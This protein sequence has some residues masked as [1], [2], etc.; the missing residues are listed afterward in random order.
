MKADASAQA[1]QGEGLPRC[2][3]CGTPYPRGDD[4]LGCPVCRLRVALQP[5]AA[6]TGEEIPSS[7][8]L[9]FDH[10][11]VVQRDDGAFEELG[12]GAMGV[13]YKALDTVLGRAVALKVI[14][15]QVAAR[16]E[17]RHTDQV[18]DASRKRLLGEAQLARF[19]LIRGFLGNLLSMV[20]HV[21][22]LSQRLARDPD[23]AIERPA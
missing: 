21:E 5:E 3:A 19:D 1:V 6:A 12:R 15:A 8:E 20:D 9:R 10:Y 4:R 16:P 14:D 13:T 22:S 11:A 17:A 18:L 7:D 2:P 23:D